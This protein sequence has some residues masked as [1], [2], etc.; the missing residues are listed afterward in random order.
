M[1]MEEHI[2]MQTQTHFQQVRPYP[3]RRYFARM[4]D[5]TLYGILWLCIQYVVFRWD[6]ESGLFLNILINL[7]TLAMMLFLEPL[8]LYTWGTTPGKWLF[9]L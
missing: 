8:L 4:L 7:I 1:K 3:G 9:G 2:N 6:P 5:I